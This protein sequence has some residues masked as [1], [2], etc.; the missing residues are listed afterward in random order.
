MSAAIPPSQF[1]P[2]P[3][4]AKIDPPTHKALLALGL[5]EE[6]LGDLDGRDTPEYV[7]PDRV[8]NAYKALVLAMN[9]LRDATAA[10]TE[11]KLR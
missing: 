6:A 11:D 3:W 1:P 9:L 8:L 4:K 2:L 10:G 7:D 5:I